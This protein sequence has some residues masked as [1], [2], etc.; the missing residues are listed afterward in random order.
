MSNLNREKQ[1]LKKHEHT[2]FLP[3]VLP[4]FPTNVIQ[5]VFFRAN[6]YSLF[7]FVLST[8]PQTLDTL[9]RVVKSSRLSTKITTY[10]VG[11]GRLLCLAFLYGWRFLS[12]TSLDLPLTLTTQ[13]STGTSKLSDNPVYSLF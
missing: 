10:L 5:T 3:S 1:N 13:P 12:K 4:S 8:F 2:N 9:F 11:I 6:N 7:I